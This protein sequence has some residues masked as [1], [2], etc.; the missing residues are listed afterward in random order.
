MEVRPTVQRPKANKLANVIGKSLVAGLI[1][2]ETQRLMLPAETKAAL[3]NARLGSD[4][5]VL[6]STKAAIKTGKNFGKTFDL[7]SIAEKAKTM[8]PEMV[9]TAN[10]ANKQLNKTFLG[11][12]L[13]FAGIS[14]AAAIVNKVRESKVE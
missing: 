2:S 8:Y 7:D 12:A 13:V 14:T 4:K 9:K 5:F 3:K 11:S 1:A 10:K 6:A